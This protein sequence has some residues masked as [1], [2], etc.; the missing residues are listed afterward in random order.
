QRH[1]L[2]DWDAFLTYYDRVWGYTKR[3]KLS[4][5]NPSILQSY[6][7]NELRLAE[8]FTSS[9]KSVLD[10]VPKPGSVAFST[11]TGLPWLHDLCAQY[12][13][14]LH[15]CPY[16]GLQPQP[17][18]SVIAEV[19]PSM[20]HKRYTYPQLANRDAEDA[21]AIAYWLREQDVK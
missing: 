4:S 2:A 14:V 16:H 1:A 5:R 19:Y 8:K 6:D 15:V 12:A 10:L 20:L 11:H 18:N 21:Y 3:D 17:H 9:A 7:R 13:S